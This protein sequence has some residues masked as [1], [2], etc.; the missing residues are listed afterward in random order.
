[1]QPVLPYSVATTSFQTVQ[2][3]VDAVVDIVRRGI[4]VQ[5]VELVDEVMIRA[6][7]K[8]VKAEGG[9]LWEEIPM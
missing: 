5:C 4:A 7:N 3:A 6:I 2:N 9:K 1:L 8:K